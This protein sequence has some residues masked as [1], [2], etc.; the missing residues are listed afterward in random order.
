MAY[1]HH[2][3]GVTFMKRFFCRV[4]VIALILLFVSSGATAAPAAQVL[5]TDFELPNK[6]KGLPSKLSE[7]NI[8]GSSSTGCN[9][10]ERAY[11]TRAVR[12]LRLAA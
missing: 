10:A 8:A 9:D 1:L 6:V 12:R 4:P 2:R 11:P 5:G 3:Y 7:F